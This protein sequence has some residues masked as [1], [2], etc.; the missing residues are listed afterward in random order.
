MRN[1]N[2]VA[3]HLEKLA[4]R[5]NVQSGGTAMRHPLFSPIDAPLRSRESDHFWSDFVRNFRSSWE[6]FPSKIS[7]SVNSLLVGPS[8]MASSHSSSS[9][10]VVE[11][12]ELSLSSSSSLPVDIIDSLFTNDDGSRASFIILSS[13]NSYPTPTAAE[14]DDDASGGDEKKPPAYSAVAVASSRIARSAEDDVFV[15]AAKAAGDEA[16]RDLERG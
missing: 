13:S 7:A 10:D 9:M 15:G 14:D 5:S 1:P 2:D 16:P 11:S 8:S 12:E 6:D 3:T 4:R